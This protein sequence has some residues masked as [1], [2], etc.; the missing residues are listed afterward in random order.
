MVDSMRH[1][2]IWSVMT[3]RRPR[4]A[5]REI[6]PV[7]RIEDTQLYITEPFWVSL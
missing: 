3:C 5:I 2:W 7:Y 4:R 1:V 6:T